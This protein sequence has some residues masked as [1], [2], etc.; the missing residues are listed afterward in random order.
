MSPK[1]HNH[2]TRSSPKPSPN[3]YDIALL[4]ALSFL[5]DNF[6][7]ATLPHDSEPR[8]MKRQRRMRAAYFEESLQDLQT[9]CTARANVSTPV[10]PA[11]PTSTDIDNNT[12][13]TILFGNLK[14]Q[15]VLHDSKG[16]SY[17]FSESQSHV[18]L[19]SFIGS[20]DQAMAI[21]VPARP[22]NEV[23]PPS[24]V[25]KI[26]FVF[27]KLADSF[28]TKITVCSHTSVIRLWLCLIRC[29]FNHSTGQRF[30][31]LTI[32]PKAFTPRFRLLHDCI[33]TAA[34]QHAW[35]LCVTTSPL[36]RLCQQDTEA[37]FYLFF[38]TEDEIWSVLIS[39]V[40]VD[41]QTIAD[42]DIL[43]FFGAGISTLWKYHW[44]C[45]FDDIPWYTTAV[46]NSFDLEHSGFLSTLPFERKLSS[47][48]NT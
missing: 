41:E 40:T 6:P 47:T 46:V 8:L 28:G 7:K 3:R 25:V 29:F 2:Q 24:P 21:E 42:M 20:K 12:Y 37:S 5:P 36:C 38:L 45:V 1:G 30:W 18:D 15:N 48:I 17:Q 39:F 27:N 33:S 22:T 9:Q 11:A 19:D 32:P 14:L 43:C 13:N 44:R 10:A 26:Q 16:R 34:L 31:F 23:V 35:N 4:V